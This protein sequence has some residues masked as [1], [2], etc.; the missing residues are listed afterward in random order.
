MRLSTSNSFTGTVTVNG[1]NLFAA[2]ESALGTSAAGTMVNNGAALLLDGGFWFKNESLTLN[3]TNPAALT[4]LGAVTNTWSGNVILQQTAGI[5]VPG[6]GGALYLDSIIGCCAG[7][8]SGPGGFTKTGPGELRFFG[9]PPN[10]FT[11]PTTITGGLV[12]AARTQGPALSGNVTVD[13]PGTTLRTGSVT[14][15]R[16]LPFGANMTVQNGALWA[17]SAGEIELLNRFVGNGNT[18]LGTGSALTL[19]NVESCTFSGLL[20]GSGALNKRG[21]ATFQVTANSYSYTGLATVVEGTYK[22]D[23]DL[24]YAPAMVKSGAILRGGGALGDVIVEAGGIVKVDR[25][26]SGLAGG[27]F[28]MNSVNFQPS[29]GVLSLEFFGPS[30]T[31]GNDELYVNGAVSLGNLNLSAGFLYPPHEGDVVTL[32]ANGVAGAVNGIISGFPEGSVQNIGNIPVVVSYVGGDGNDVTLTVTNLP[33]RAG[34]AQLVS[35]QFGSTLVP[36]D[37]SQLFLGVTNRSAT[38]ISNLRGTLRSLTDGVIVT[39][40]EAAFPNLAPNTGGANATPFQIRTDSSFPCGAGA[41]FELILT[42]SNAPATAILYTLLGAS[43][44]ALDFD[45]RDD[46]VEIAANTFSSVVNNFTIELWANPAG[47]R[48]QTAEA[49]SGVSGVNVAQ[50]QIQR[51]AVFPDRGNVAYG[52]SHVSAGLSIGRNGISAY[53][54]GTNYLPSRLVYSNAV[55]GWTHVALVYANRAPRLYVNG[56][57]VRSGAASAFT[58]VHPS[59]SL[60]GS[61]QADYGNFQGQLDEVRIWNVARSQSQIQSN[62]TISLTGAEANLVT[63]FRCDEGA[64]SVLGDSASTSPNP[65]GRLTNGVAFVFPG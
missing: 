3:S 20:S 64:G 1:G 22:V 35:G 53:E 31:G 29:G 58:S 56:T 27:A 42:A 25:R 54:Q 48:T 10:T 5:D 14:A 19:S 16:D 61:P 12:E 21:P 49:T 65:I 43:G 38:T 59:G 7:I 62:M 57:L 8:V 47:N 13:G 45:G 51:F 28:I 40:A 36:N 15:N 11:G 24:L 6:S 2:H 34:G 37:C 9:G 44:Y 33:F 55:S 26:Y 60:G 52:S 32:I 46:Q 41:Q 30:P 4:S 63:Y 23:G 17:I 18:D 50:H 39:I